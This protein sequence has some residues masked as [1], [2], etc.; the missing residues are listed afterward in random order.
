MGIKEI[1]GRSNYPYFRSLIN[2]IEWA[3]YAVAA[4]CFMGGFFTP[5]ARESEWGISILAGVFVGILIYCVGRVFK[6]T[7]LMVADAA[8]CLVEMATRKPSLSSSSAAI[9]LPGKKLHQAPD[10]K[11]EKKVRIGRG[12][13]DLGERSIAEVVAMLEA[14]ELTPDDI[15]RDGTAWRPLAECEDLKF[16][17]AV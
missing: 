1:R 2:V 9:V 5:W 10:W 14:G 8:D 12:G 15:Y 13:H 11:R 4:L 16:K 3:I 6:E 17:E 7:S